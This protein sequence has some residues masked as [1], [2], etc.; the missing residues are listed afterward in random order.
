MARK[1]ISDALTSF[2]DANGNDLPAWPP[3]FP[4]LSPP[5]NSTSPEDRVQCGLLFMAKALEDLL[6]DQQDE[7]NPLNTHLHKVLHQCIIRVTRLRPCVVTV[8]GG[9][10]SPE[11]TPPKMPTCTFQRKE[12]GHTLLGASRDFLSWLE[13]EVPPNPWLHLPRHVNLDEKQIVL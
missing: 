2:D 12:W 7:L 5:L 1:E 6:K 11:P 9:Q 10:C 13:H 4:V 8:L 3:G